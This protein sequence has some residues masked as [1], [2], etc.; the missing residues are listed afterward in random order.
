MGIVEAAGGVGGV[1]GGDGE[2][3]VLGLR[4]PVGGREGEPVVSSTIKRRRLN[5]KEDSIKNNEE[6]VF[7]FKLL[8]IISWRRQLFDV[9]DVFC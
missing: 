9:V 5:N 2:H 3:R 7:R 8:E 6:I 1:G 4:R